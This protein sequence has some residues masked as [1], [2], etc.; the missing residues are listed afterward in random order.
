MRRHR[1]PIRLP[2]A[3]VKHTLQPELRN[4]LILLNLHAHLKQAVAGP[5]AL[6]QRRPTAAYD[7][8]F[9]GL[10]YHFEMVCYLC[11]GLVG[12]AGELWARPLDHGGV[13]YMIEGSRVT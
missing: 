1:R 2:Q 11:A 12:G 9:G 8:G 10:G 3:L 6:F 4:T 5:H 13:S 7:D